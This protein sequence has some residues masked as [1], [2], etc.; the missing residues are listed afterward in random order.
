MIYD[1]T[2]ILKQHDLDDDALLDLSDR[3]YGAGCDDSSV[4]SCDG[5]ISVSFDRES[6][7]L[8]AAIRS[9]VGQVLR[10]GV[11]VEHVRIEAEAVGA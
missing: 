9:A 6:D 5:V 11:T 4:S 1:F 2:L 3:V 8:E 7:T 10:T